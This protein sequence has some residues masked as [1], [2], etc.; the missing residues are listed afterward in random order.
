MQRVVIRLA[1]ILALALSGAACAAKLAYH[2][3]QD[4]A[5]KGNWDLAVARLTR[6]VQKDPDNIGYR[7]TLENARIQASRMHFDLARKH[8]QAQDLEKAAEE[9]DIASKYD[10]SNKSA[11]DELALVRARIRNREAA[12][13]E[14]TDF[15]GK[16][17]RAAARSAV[18]VLS[19]RSLAPI[20]LNYR[21]QSLQRLLETLGKLAGVNVLFDEGFRDKNVT[22]NLSGVTFREALDQI[23]MVNRLFYKVLDQN[24]III[25]A[26]S[27]A[28]RRAY[29]AMLMQT[30]YL[31][32]AE[33]KD[34][35]TI[36][37]TAVGT[38]ARV[39][40]NPTLGAINVIGTSDQIA[41]VSRLLDLNDKA[42]GEV[43]VEVQI[44]EVDRE[45]IKNY[46]IEIANNSGVALTFAPNEDP[47]GSNVSVRAHL[48]SSINASDFIVTLPSTILA[49]FLQTE[50][51]T[52]ILASPR[53]RAAEGKKTSLKIGTEVP[54]PVTTFTAA[55]TG[56]VG[57][58][59]APATSFQYRNVG[60][61][62]ELTPRVTPNGDIVLEMAAEFSLPGQPSSLAGQSLPTFLTR[63]VNG[64][65]RLRDGET[66]LLGGLL[67]DAETEAFRGIIGLQ[68]I[69][70]LNRI[71]TGT[72]KA[73]RQTEIL[74]SITPHL[75]RA[76]KISEEDLRSMFIGTQEVVRVPGAGD[77]L[78]G[79]PDVVPSPSPSPLVGSPAPPPGPAT[80]RPAGTVSGSMSDVEAV[81]TPAAT[82]PPTPSVVPTPL[83]A[84][85]PDFVPPPEVGPLVPEPTPAPGTPGFQTLAPSPAAA[86]LPGDMGPPAPTPS[87]TPRAP[88]RTPS[89]PS[90]LASPAP[91]TGAT[92]ANGATGA[93]AA[94]RMASA[95]PMSASFSPPEVRVGTGGT[96]T[97][98]L[99][100]MGVSDLTSVALAVTYD[101]AILEAVDVNAG[102]LLTLDGQAVAA[103]RGL[104]TGRVR[105]RFS[106]ASGTA[107]SGVVA[108][109][110]FRALKAGSSTLTVG[111]LNLTAGGR[112]ATPVVSPARI[113]VAQ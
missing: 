57:G 52:K 32:N 30:F 54:V 108:S 92:G 56:G 35:E 109:I 95:A 39:V 26:E 48:L 107:G 85:E 22:V 51:N 7:I 82:P 10:A 34:V 43:V 103:D 75:V 111:N 70:I 80:G 93:Q 76:P 106:R 18:P 88:G 12:L 94:G 69:P 29:D 45:K 90:A 20:A 77:D 13:N 113:V 6:A 71:F 40:S 99:V 11:S 15:E 68:S 78:F 27:Q 110:T 66:A 83:P 58:T 97:V 62:L 42:H 59:F 84:R 5:K 16:R 55:Q 104:E 63:N 74:F 50:G 61:N 21:D 31:Q 24:T 36:V 9:L 19:P 96:A 73:A 33:T 112:S 25:V 14:M 86:P 81:R 67:Q 28:K 65:L 4:E 23:T 41:I 46:G 72:E 79:V 53:L 17:Q 1:V 60:V 98:G 49:T 100:V 89:G 38:T 47:T 64:T 101:P 8:L 44:L 105:A 102:S 3:G 2:Q 87:P 37:K 91:G